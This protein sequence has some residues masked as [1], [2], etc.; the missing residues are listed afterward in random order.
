MKKLNKSHKKSQPMKKQM[1]FCASEKHE[2]KIKK[3]MKKNKFSSMSEAI[4][5]CIEAF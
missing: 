2:L 1:A 3:I 5:A 4:R